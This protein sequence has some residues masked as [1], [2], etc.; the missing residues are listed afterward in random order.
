M[1]W[2]FTVTLL[3]GALVYLI[4]AATLAFRPAA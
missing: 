3:T 2:G 1:N 4:A